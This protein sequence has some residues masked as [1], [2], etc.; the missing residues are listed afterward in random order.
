MN[1]ACR[2]QKSFIF[3]APGIMGF[4]WKIF[5]TFMDSYTASKFVITS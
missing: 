1:Y 4:F 5:S 2:L 3:N